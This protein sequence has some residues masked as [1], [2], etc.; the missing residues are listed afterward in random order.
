MTFIN[1]DNKLILCKD[2]S[3]SSFTSSST[4]SST[5]P[6]SLLSHPPFCPIACLSP[7]ERDLLPAETCQRGV[8][9]GVVVILESRDSQVLVTRRARHM[10]TFP[11]VW[12][13]PGGHIELGETLL[14][15][16]LREL[17]E[18]TGLDVVGLVETSEVLCLWE[19]VFPH[20]LTMGQPSRH[21]IV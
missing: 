4:S 20:S 5:S 1:R 15:A 7:E 8:N 3:T 11:G 2:T 14:Q 13:P 16:G 10:R 12:V 9:V 19:S 6:S 18:E 21:H 17:Q